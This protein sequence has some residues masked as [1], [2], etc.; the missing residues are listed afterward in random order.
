M[1]GCT[2]DR[3]REEDQSSLLFPFFLMSVIHPSVDFTQSLYW[4]VNFL[5]L[6]EF[7]FV[8]VVRVAAPHIASSGI[9]F[10]NYEHT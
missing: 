2:S 3:E 7:S 1:K 4:V 10:M 6:D 9:S 8:V 5:K